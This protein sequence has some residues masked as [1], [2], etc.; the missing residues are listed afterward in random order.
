M[1][2]PALEERRLLIFVRAHMPNAFFAKFRRVGPE[3]F[4]LVILVPLVVILGF[5][6]SRFSPE[7]LS[8]VSAS[9][10]PI[11]TLSSESSPETSA[12]PSAVPSLVPQTSTVVLEVKT[13]T[14]AKTYQLATQSETTVADLL[15]RAQREQ[16]F[17]LE[18]RNFGGSL[19]IFVESIN[20][21]RN[22]STKKLYWSLYV[23]G[24]FSPLGASSTTVRAGDTVTWKYE[25]MHEE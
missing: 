1:S 18:M 17:H 20:G 11:S 23:N 7:R 4:A 12:T 22:D 8:S 2:A 9:P 5:I 21:V 16:G 6:L 24:A 19:G 14:S 3:V 10:T 25:P 15:I 13:P